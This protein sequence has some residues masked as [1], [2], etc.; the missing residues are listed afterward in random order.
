[1]GFRG[2]GGDGARARLSLVRAN[3]ARR[4]P[5]GGTR[6]RYVSSLG[7]RQRRRVGAR[8]SVTTWRRVLAIDGRSAGRGTLL[9]RFVPVLMTT[10]R[11]FRKRMYISSRR[12]APPG[13]LGL[14]RLPPFEE[15]RLRN[16]V[17]LHRGRMTQHANAA[18]SEYPPTR[19]AL[20]LS[21][22]LPGRPGRTRQPSNRRAFAAHES[23]PSAP[24]PRRCRPSGG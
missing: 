13:H 17:R 12:L 9:Y 3:S 24:A 21:R 5:P 1:M 11:L 7:R 22:P 6:L 23:C 10:S 19:T 16:R 4:E 20:V 8:R 14:L 15:P 18:A 2:V